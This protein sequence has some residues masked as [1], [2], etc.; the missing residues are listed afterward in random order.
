V[1]G[2]ERE[3]AAKLELDTFGAIGGD[4]A[5]L[6]RYQKLVEKNVLTIQNLMKE[7]MRVEKE[8]YEVKKKLIMLDVFD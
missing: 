5:H 6:D 2:R 3:R 8:L 1:E 7:Q 4:F